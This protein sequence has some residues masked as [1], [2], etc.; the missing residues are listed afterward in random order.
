MA[1]IYRFIEEWEFNNIRHLNKFRSLF[2]AAMIEFIKNI[3]IA[4][5]LL[6]YANYKGAVW[7]LRLFNY[8]LRLLFVREEM[9][10]QSEY[11]EFIRRNAMNR[12]FK[13]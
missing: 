13:F 7:G 12:F 11:E 3:T 10:W 6:L 5:S 8:V 2:A 4:F 9:H 1:Y